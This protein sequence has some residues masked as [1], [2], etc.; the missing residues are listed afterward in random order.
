MKPLIYSFLLVFFSS[1]NVFAQ[2]SLRPQVG[3][4][5]ASLDYESVHGSV[6]GKTG[7]HFGVDLQIGRP[8]YIQ[9][10]MS[11]STTKLEIK[12]FGNIQVSNL[13]VPIMVGYK[14]FENDDQKA[15]G[16][17]LFVGPNFS[18]NVNE[19]IDGVFTDIT[20]DD[21]K[22]FHV[23]GIVG[24]GLDISILFID[25][26]YK[27]GITEFIKTDKADESIHYFIAN[28]GIRIGF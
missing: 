7:L 21:I 14:L 16:L 19:K 2:L 26:G 8:L 20:K 13:D 17:R 24:A 28:G 9:P 1:M 5:F 25:V 6:K 23:S 10:G 11:F 15:F 3:V 22:N 27:F 12:E 18:F 4:N